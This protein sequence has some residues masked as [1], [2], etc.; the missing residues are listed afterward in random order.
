M[1][2]SITLLAKLQKIF[3]RTMALLTQLMACIILIRLKFFQRAMIWGIIW[4]RSSLEWK[5]VLRFY[6]AM[7]YGHGFR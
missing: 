7:V 4:L 3:W 2:G 5:T 1:H 6:L